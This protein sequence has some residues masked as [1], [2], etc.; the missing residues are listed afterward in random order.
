MITLGSG[1]K[2]KALIEKASSLINKSAWIAVKA[3][4]GQS[5]DQYI[6]VPVKVVDAKVSYGKVKVLIEPIGGA[7]A[8]WIHHD[9]L[10]FS[11]D[12]ADGSS[13]MPGR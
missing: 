10:W 3:L 13:A 1:A 2:G 11:L 4:A 12:K 6:Y 8:W 7:G 9:R 5:A